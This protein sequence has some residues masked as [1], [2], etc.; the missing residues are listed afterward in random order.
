MERGGEGKE[1]LRLPKAGKR[2]RQGSGCQQ[3]GSLTALLRPKLGAGTQQIISDI[4]RHQQCARIGRT[5]V[6]VRVC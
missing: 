5:Q 4:R 6:V 2:Q 1:G 3:E